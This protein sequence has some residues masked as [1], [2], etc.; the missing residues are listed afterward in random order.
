MSLSPRERE[1]LDALVAAY[2]RLPKAEPPAAVD[3]AVRANARAALQRVR[4]RWPGLL[5]TAATMTIAIGL[6]WQLR[7]AEDAREAQRPSATSMPAPQRTDPG[8]TTEV[9][10]DGTAVSTDPDL[11]ERDVKA[12]DVPETPRAFDDFEETPAAPAPPPHDPSAR[13]AEAEAAAPAEPRARAPVPAPQPIPEVEQASQA[14]GEPPL[15]KQADALFESKT[16][17]APPPAAIRVPAAPPAVARSSAAATRDAP[18]QERLSRDASANAIEAL[19]SAPTDRADARLGAA[20]AT[21]EPRDWLD[22]IVRLLRTGQ[23][24]RA[25]ESLREFRAAHPDAELPP[26]LAELL[27]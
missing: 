27:P 21:R 14:S 12:R 23:R 22:E 4:P 25:I 13:R 10:E 2:G 18:Q 16:A 19:E 24:E 6:A 15:R 26:E 1:R 9:V 17:P 11:R 5:A 3:A 7:D 20:A 8:R